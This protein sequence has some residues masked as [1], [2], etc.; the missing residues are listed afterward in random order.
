MPE[1]S[2]EDLSGSRFE[3]VRLRNA[4]FRAVDLSGARFHGVALHGAVLRGVELCDVKIQDEVGGLT[5]NG[6]DVG[7]LIDAVLDERYPERGMMRPADPAGFREAWDV[8][9]RLWEGTV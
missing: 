6:V 8:V 1:F 7:P 9:E 5:I 2:H 4:R 3:R